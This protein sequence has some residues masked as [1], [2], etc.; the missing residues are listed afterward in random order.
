M[1]SSKEQ[2]LAG[3][4]VSFFT[5]TFKAPAAAMKIKVTYLF[6]FIDPGKAHILT[7]QLEYLLST[8]LTY[9]L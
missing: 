2:G 4:D 9:L 5:L 7:L 8:S 3:L 6:Q 1:A